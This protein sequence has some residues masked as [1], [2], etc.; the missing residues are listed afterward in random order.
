M[1]RS[2]RRPGA[3]TD[4]D[5][6][7]IKDHMRSLTL[8][9][10]PLLNVLQQVCTNLLVGLPTQASLQCAYAFLERCKTATKMPS[11]R[12]LTYCVRAFS[13][14]PA[15]ACP[16]MNALGRLT[17]GARTSFPAIARV[18]FRKTALRIRRIGILP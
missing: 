5:H 6:L 11:T 17:P 7:P 18:A 3:R 10:W 13:G 4:L 2:L 1:S 15:N 8:P 12:P 16:V 14:K 9:P